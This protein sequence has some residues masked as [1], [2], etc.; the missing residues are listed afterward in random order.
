MIY[1]YRCKSCNLKFDVFTTLE[2]RNVVQEC[3]HCKTITGIRQ[4][5]TSNFDIGGTNAQKLAA[6]DGNNKYRKNHY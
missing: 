2:K 3:P 5:S 6:L 4:I 1:E